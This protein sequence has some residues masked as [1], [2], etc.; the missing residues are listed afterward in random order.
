MIPKLTRILL[1]WVAKNTQL[2]VFIVSWYNNDLK[3]MMNIN[4]YICVFIYIYIRIYIYIYLKNKTGGIPFLREQV[5][6]RFPR[7]E[8]LR[9]SNP[10][11]ICGAFF[12]MTCPKNA[13]PSVEQT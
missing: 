1:K 3:A 10:L 4:I 2:V 9:K 5:G 6:E 13:Y 8:I 12:S 7:Q 11:Q